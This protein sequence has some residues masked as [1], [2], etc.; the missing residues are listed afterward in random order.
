[1]PKKRRVFPFVVILLLLGAA[2]GAIY[3]FY[4]SPAADKTP[5]YLTTT[6]SKGDVIQ[7]VTATGDL[8]PVV[9]VEVSSQISG[10]IREVLVDFNSPVKKGDVLARIDPATYESRLSQ[11]R[12]DYAS[13]QA[14]NT[15]VRLNTER[16]RELRLKQLVAQQDLDQADAQLAQSAAQLLTREAAVK[17]AETDLS[18][19]TLLAPIDGIVIDRL[20]EVGKTVAASL[21]APTLFTI[22]NDLSQMRILAAVAEADIG[23]IEVGQPAHFTVDAYPSRQFRGKVSLIRNSAKNQQSV[24]TY[25]TQIDVR[26]EDLRLKPGMT[27]NVSIVIANRPATLKVANAA[28]RARIPES[29][30]PAKKPDDTPKVGTSGPLVR[31]ETKSEIPASSEKSDAPKRPTSGGPGGNANPEQR[32]KLMALMQE[33]NLDFRSTTPPSPEVAAKFLEAAKAQGL[34]IS[35]RL[36]SRLEG[37]APNRDANTPTTRTLYKLTGTA[38]DQK[39]EPVSVK[40]GITDGTTTEVLEGLAEGDALVTSV[41]IPGAPSTAAGPASNPF[42]TMGGSSRSGRSR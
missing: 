23:Q 40:L 37:A 20:A 14:N 25:L 42:N 32:A 30:L 8:D 38:P 24:V 11:A 5:E 6:V 34:E 27:A 21:N 26:N 17:N 28:L 18:R 31:S 10:L 2:A 3:Y 41:I 16:S 19:C 12:A 39:I 22:V 9:S 35:E 1:M 7:V 4:L 15:L 13:A 29:L 36:R 33:H